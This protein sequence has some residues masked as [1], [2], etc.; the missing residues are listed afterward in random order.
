MKKSNL[1]LIFLLIFFF[2][3][4]NVFGQIELSGD[5]KRGEYNNA[6]LNCEPIVITKTVEIIA[7]EGTNNGF[8]I[9]DKN[10]I[11]VSFFIEDRKFKPKAIGYT[12]EPGKY[13]A[14]PNLTEGKN[15]ATIKLKLQ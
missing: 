2:N 6:E 4:I 8:W 14:Y 9:E 12:L 10:G 13:W 7:V 1:I 3:S 5:Q 11:V 15:E